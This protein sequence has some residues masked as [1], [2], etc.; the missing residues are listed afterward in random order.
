[1]ADAVIR[2]PAEPPW[3]PPRLRGG[4]FTNL[5]SEPNLDK[6][7]ASLLSDLT[8][9][10]FLVVDGGSLRCYSRSSAI[11]AG[12]IPVTYK[13]QNSIHV[14][15]SPTTLSPTVRPVWLEQMIERVPVHL[16]QY[17]EKNLKYV[18]SSTWFPSG[19]YSETA[20]IATA[21]GRCI[22]DAPE[23]RQKLV[24]LLKTK[25]QLQL[26]ELSNTPEVI[27]LEA[28]RALSRDGREHAYVREMAAEANRLLEAHSEMLRLSPEKV[29]PPAQKPRIAHSSA[30][31]SRKRFDV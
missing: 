28:T 24:L 4:Y 27:V 30:I 23:L 5:V 11:Y 31:T 19:L 21:L 10:K 2:V 20:A 8:D 1:V 9:R 14:H 15:V 25:N 26:S 12:D 6:R 3:R 13:I 7:T 29:G 16:E 22:I 17:R 18:K